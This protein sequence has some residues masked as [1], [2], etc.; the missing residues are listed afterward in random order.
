MAVLMPLKRKYLE[1]KS[2]G[3]HVAG[4]RTGGSK[5]KKKGTGL[6]PRRKAYGPF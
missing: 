4:S 5:K 2:G 6:R 1:R 3:T